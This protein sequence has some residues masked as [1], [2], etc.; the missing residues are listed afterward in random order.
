MSHMGVIQIDSVNVVVRSQE[1]PLFARLGAHRRDLID[2][3]TASGDLFEYWVHEACHVPVADHPLWR[4]RMAAPHRWSG[5]R[6][7]GER[8]PAVVADVL[9]RVHA[10]GPVTVGDLRTRPKRAGSWWDWDDTKAALELLFWR[11]DITARR[12]PRD[13]ARVYDVVER[14]LPADVVNAPTPTRRDAHRELARRAVRHLGVATLDDIADYHRLRTAEV[15]DVLADLV[16]SGEVVPTVVE[17]WSRPAFT[18]ADVSIPRT[19]HTR[20]VLSPFD[21][22]VWHRPRAARLFGFDYR[23]EI[24]TPASQRRYGYY[25]LPFLVNDH[26]VA[27]VDLKSDR[28]TGRLLVRTAWIEAAHDAAPHSDHIASELTA[29]LETM[30]V[31]LGLDRGVDV[32]DTTGDL[33]VRLRAVTR[34]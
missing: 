26:L 23:L 17:G 15:R 33:A 28:T 29:E 14:A 21:P 19:M 30:A 3:A 4:W 10:D 16:E 5:P 24:Y 7:I 31:W 13:F 11:G 6:D 1:L 2:H 9:R 27:R 20:A 18:P 22:V 25:V 34:R 12:R 8:S 32:A